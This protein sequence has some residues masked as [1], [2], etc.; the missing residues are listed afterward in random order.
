MTASSNPPAPMSDPSDREQGT[1]VESND[2]PTPDRELPTLRT[3]LSPAYLG[4]LLLASVLLVFAAG[5]GLVSWLVCIPAIVA[6]GA[7]LFEGGSW[8]T[9]GS[10]A[11]AVL[12]A[13]ATAWG[14]PTPASVTPQAGEPGPAVASPGV[15]GSLGIEVGDVSDLWNS[16]DSNPRITSG[17]VHYTDPGQYSS[18]RYRFDKW[19]NLSGA[20][21]PDT[22]AVYGLMVKGNI[23]RAATSQMY[24]HLCFALHP[25]SQE[26]IDSYFDTGLGG[27]GLEKFVGLTQEAEWE[28]GD[29]TW[30]LSIVENVL[31]L[32]VL[33]EDVD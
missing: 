15:P 19:G 17:L 25:Y 6:L 1:D 24:L 8:V 14:G 30:R 28:L 23:T 3:N 11:L 29:Q 13:L 10:G 27:G 20:Y 12:I 33:G 5:L 7:T 32:R 31:T 9:I 18:F 26:C 16:L 4:V 21:D 22:E 2:E